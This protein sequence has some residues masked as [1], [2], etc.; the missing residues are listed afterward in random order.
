MQI[1]MEVGIRFWVPDLTS[2]QNM[3]KLNFR[4]EE[5]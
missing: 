5:L 3:T 4:N 1:K 2:A